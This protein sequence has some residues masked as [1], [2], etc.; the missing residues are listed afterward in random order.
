MPKI[1]PSFKHLRVAEWRLW[2]KEAYIGIHTGFCLEPALNANGYQH[3][4]VPVYA[5]IKPYSAFD[6]PAPQ[7]ERWIQKNESNN[8][9]ILCR[10]REWLNR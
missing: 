6:K 5:T 7:V 1:R 2:Q 3:Y 8:Q 10:I 4:P 9:N